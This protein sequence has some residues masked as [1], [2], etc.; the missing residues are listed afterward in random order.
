MNYKG[1]TAAC[2]GN[3]AAVNEL[4]K[5]LDYTRKPFN[6]NLLPMPI[7]VLDLL[8]IKTGKANSGG[9]WIIRCPEH[10]EGKEKE[11]SLNIHQVTGHYKCHACQVKGGDI[12]AFYRMVTGKSFV[13][14]A[15][16]LGA[17]ESNK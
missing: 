14:A 4:N 7:V 15:M 1:K 12:L 2:C 8:G 13:E 6:K 17:W 3:V 16:S 9:Y 5:R 10:K 11:P